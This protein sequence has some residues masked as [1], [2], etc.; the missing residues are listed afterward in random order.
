VSAEHQ[1]GISSA[2]YS[3]RMEVGHT[4]APAAGTQTAEEV[5]P[6]L[7]TVAAAHAA[8]VAL[9]S[10]QH[11]REDAD[12]TDLRG[13]YLTSLAQNAVDH[14]L[15]VDD[16][17]AFSRAIH[18]IAL[19][20]SLGV[21]LPLP[22]RGETDGHLEKI[23]EHVDRQA[24]SWDLP[25][26]DFIVEDGDEARSRVALR[27]QEAM[28]AES[29]ERFEG[30]V[31]IARCTFGRAWGV[32]LDNDIAPASEEITELHTRIESDHARRSQSQSIAPARVIARGRERGAEY[33][34]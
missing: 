31:D 10:S 17:I 9:A 19:A 8:V 27:D 5:S 4:I 34:R 25:D 3:G 22:E 29:R 30:L 16:Q 26:Q 23:A 1:I 28:D 6:E 33:S 24:P 21:S 32:V 2:P 14:A 18:V 12:A 11:L 7:A 20:K 13:A 15:A